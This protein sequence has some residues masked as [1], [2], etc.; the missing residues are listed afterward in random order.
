MARRHNEKGQATEFF[1]TETG[2]VFN[3][4]VV[5]AI[6][7][8]LGVAEKIEPQQADIGQLKSELNWQTITTADDDIV[9]HAMKGAVVIHDSD[10]EFPHPI[11]G[12]RVRNEQVESY[13]FSWKK[14]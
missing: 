6:L 5:Q 4:K 12:A 2:E 8:K 1:A 7:K 13:R 9:L 11:F 10:S 14:Q 3:E